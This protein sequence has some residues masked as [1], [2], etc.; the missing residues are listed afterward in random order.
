[1]LDTLIVGAGPYGLSVA[2][3]LRKHGT[4]FRIVGRLMD[5]WLSHMPKGM[6]LKS[7]GFASSLSDPSQE[8]TLR[9]YCADRGIAYADT[10]LPVTLDTFSSYGAA[11]AE[12]MVPELEDKIVTAIEFAPSGFLATLNTGEKVT[13]ARV[14]LAVGITH[15]GY[16]PKELSNLPA[17][18][19]S[20]SFA[21]SD[22]EAFRGRNVVVVGGGS[23]AIDLAV[24]LHEAGAAVQLVARNK[25]LKFHNKPNPGKRSFWQRIRSPQSGLGPGLKSRFCCDAPRVFRHLP[26]RFRLRAVRTH[27][28]PSGGWFIKDRLMNHV[29]LLLGWSV[30]SADVRDGRACLRLRGSEGSIQEIPADHVIAATGFKVDVERLQFLDQKIRSKIDTVESTPILSS[31]F[32]SSVP[33]LFFVGVSAAN[34]FGPL[35]R[36]AF[37]ADFAAR[38][39]MRALASP[40]ISASTLS[41]I[42]ESAGTTTQKL[43]VRSG[44]SCEVSASTQG[45]NS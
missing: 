25:E 28:G 14:V 21:H 1:M 17:E 2:A 3:H 37:G 9:Q 29:P 11:F 6:M 15:Y 45:P 16:V 22:L 5:S 32:E 7:D 34:S 23:S 18:L 27:L 31:T 39:I 30:E 26:I 4:S 43:S 35:M 36:F 10:G 19:L 40:A 33:G 13:A 38:N 42:P 20:H 8:L 41:T 44:T 24:L 12:R